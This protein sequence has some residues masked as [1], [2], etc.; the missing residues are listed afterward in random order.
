MA[1]ALRVGGIYLLLVGIL[2]LIPPWGAAVFGRPMADPAITSGWGAALFALGLISYAAAANASAGA[3]I[4][5][6]LVAGYL[7][8]DADIIYYWATGAYTARNALVPVVLNIVLA[9]W[10]WMRRSRSSS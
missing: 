1:T 4:A 10:I 3:T 7:L 9:A 6:P 8:S 5:V 2:L